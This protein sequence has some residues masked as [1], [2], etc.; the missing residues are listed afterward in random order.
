MMITKKN[1][2]SILKE[3]D[4]VREEHGRLA[5]D[6]NQ[7]A[8]INLVDLFNTL[9]ENDY[10]GQDF[11]AKE[12]LSR[13]AEAVE[14]NNRSILEFSSALSDE[15]NELSSKINEL[16]SE[17]KKLEKL[18][19]DN[20]MIID[21][22]TAWINSD[23]SSNLAYKG[24]IKTGDIIQFGK[25]PQNADGKDLTPIDWQ[26][27]DIQ[28]NR[29]LLISK[30]AID[31]I[32]YNIQQADTNWS[33]CTLREWLNN[34]FLN[35]AFSKEEIT[36]I[37]ESDVSANRNPTYGLYAGEPTSDMLFLLNIDEL[38]KYFGSADSRICAPTSYA[39]KRGAL[40]KGKY[41]TDGLA[42]CRWWL[43][44]TGYR[45]DYAACVGCSGTVNVSGNIVTGSNYCV[46]PAMWVDF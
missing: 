8:I 36:R 2:K 6:N 18:Y 43:R 12:E 9:S 15:Q 34:T 24:D 4:V 31:C 5:S 44:S 14:D 17:I 33:E 13:L 41:L 37:L 23:I 40:T 32:P 19:S 10:I 25:Y 35:I 30:Y 39:K 21:E 46:R 7:R 45:H 1:Y 29:V 27:L 26:V 11:K 20:K 22:L 38:Y 3:F 42:S 28:N 16:R